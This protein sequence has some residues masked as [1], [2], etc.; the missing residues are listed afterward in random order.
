GTVILPALARHHVSTDKAGFASA[1]DWGLRTT[2]LLAVP[3]ML[4]LMLCAEP[5][6]ATIFQHGQFTAYDTRLTALSVYG[7]SF[8]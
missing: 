7:L 8:A 1:L 3:A 2:L 6:L 4:G 5:L